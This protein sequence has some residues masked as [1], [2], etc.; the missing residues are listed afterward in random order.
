[1]TWI[2]FIIGGLVTY[3]L[4]L[5]FSKESG[6]GRIFKKLR[7]APPPKS[8][9]REGLA[10]LHCESIWWGVPVTLLFAT[11][12][13]IEWIDAP[14]YW[15]AFSAIAIILHHQFTSDFKK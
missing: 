14:L 1:M 10:C 5:M 6:P 2:E 13:R 8:S 9:A 4:S 12:G 11:T 15:L 7:N 3:R